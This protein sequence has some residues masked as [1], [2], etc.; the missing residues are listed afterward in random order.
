M[1]M[2][3]QDLRIKALLV[4]D[5][6]LYRSGLK[7]A[8][9]VSGI[10]V[11]AEAETLTE[12]EMILGSGIGLDVVILDMRLPDGD[13]ITFC[14]QIAP[15]MS[16]KWIL[17]TSGVVGQETADRVREAGAQAVIM[18]GASAEEVVAVIKGVAAGTELI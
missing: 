3:R 1:G 2:V 14:S 17:L 4:D 8:L 9:G 11:V 15:T 18:K 10:A 7:E 12:A 13:G 5:H 16:L 6:F